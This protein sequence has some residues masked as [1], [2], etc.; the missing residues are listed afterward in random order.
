MKLL[1]TVRGCRQPLR[2]MER[3]LSCPA[4]HTFD[5]ARSGY[6]NL[7]QPQDRRSRAPGDS[8]EAVA[9]R[10]R[11]LDRGLEAPLVSALV[12]LLPL[13][14]GESLLDVGCGEGHHL[15]AF[16]STYGAACHGVDISVAAIE[17]AA[18]R[19]P[20]CTW[21][22][23]NADRFLPFPD[24]SFRAITTITS[25]LPA[26]ELQRVLA[27]GGRLLVAVPAED[28][29]AELRAAVLGA[30][31]ARGRGD[32]VVE[33]LSPPLALERRERIA[34]VVRLDRDALADVLTSSY[35]AVRRRERE[36][37]A[38]LAG[39]DVTLAREVLVF[40]SGLRQAP[41]SAASAGIQG[42]PGASS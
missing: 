17:L 32:R 37:L 22:V 13:G 2:A 38:G 20:G 14:H 1:C 21:V 36:R 12:E 11:F 34:R 10:R 16:R 31:N 39:M 24:V 7:L 41:D 18:R 9:A 3:H 30:A 33:Q 8:P 23:A 15:A 19:H 27:P 26:G 6:V 25:R 40:R 29:L 35:R 4:G 42:G 28:D 5:V